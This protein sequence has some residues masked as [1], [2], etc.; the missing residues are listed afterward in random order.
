MDFTK[1][2]TWIV[3]NGITALFVVA[4][5]LIDLLVVFSGTHS[6]T[7]KTEGLLI[8]PVDLAIGVTLVFMLAVIFKN[9]DHPLHVDS[10]EKADGLIKKA[11]CVAYLLLFY[12]SCNYAFKT[13]WD[14]GTIDEAAH[15]LLIS[16]W[17]SVSDWHSFYFSVYP[18]NVFLLWCTAV[19]RTVEVGFGLFNS[20]VFSRVELLITCFITIMTSY[21][22]YR[23][24]CILTSWKM[25]LCGWVLYMVYIAVSPWTV[26]FYSDSLGLIIPTGNFYLYLREPKTP[27]TRKW[28]WPLLAFLSGIAYI[29]KPQ[30]FILSIAI[31]LVHVALKLRESKNFWKSLI[32]CTIAFSVAMCIPDIQKKTLPLKIDAEQ[33]MGPVHF[34]MMGLNPETDGAFL[35]EDV[36]FSES[37]STASERTAADISRAKDRLEAYGLFGYL[38]HLRNKILVIYADGTF[39]W[40]REG[41]FWPD[42]YPETNYFISNR[43]RSIYCGSHLEG[44][45][46]YS[47]VFW[48]AF[49]FL[50]IFSVF[51]NSTHKNELLILQLSL[52]GLFLF[53]LLFEARARYIYTYAP[54]YL[55]LAV[56]GVDS[57]LT[58][59][60]N[61]FSKKLKVPQNG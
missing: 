25:A 1:G 57:I 18:N 36:E 38:K 54:I 13:G 11:C 43:V 26:I 49:L 34:F 35:Q 2:K 39:A 8:Y 40:A 46:T 45:Q 28:K 33:E 48:F 52:F 47:Q 53:E 17:T 10:E 5:V 6:W 19:L 30:T 31:L 55:M 14:A 60:K 21:F 50:S 29:L 32:V 27:F 44:W 22:V 20:A 61:I 16:H 56:V 51:G 23:I 15:E 12:W 58:R 4:M 59:T 42:E 9:L 3:T 41:G 37:F 24:L 7:N